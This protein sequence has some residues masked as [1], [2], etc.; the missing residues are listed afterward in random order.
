MTLKRANKEKKRKRGKNE[1][2]ERGVSIHNNTCS[3]ESPA[4]T[5]EVRVLGVGFKGDVVSV[6]YCRKSHYNTMFMW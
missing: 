6:E 5:N 4:I 2:R 3:K 1:R